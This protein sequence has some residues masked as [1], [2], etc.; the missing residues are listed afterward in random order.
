MNRCKKNVFPFQWRS[1]PQLLTVIF[2]RFT[3]ATAPVF[4]V[5]ENVR[6][7]FDLKTPGKTDWFSGIVVKVHKKNRQCEIDFEAK[8]GFDANRETIPFEEIVR[9][10]ATPKRKSSSP[11]TRPAKKRR[12]SA[13]K[14]MAIE[15]EAKQQLMLET[16]KQHQASTNTAVTVKR[17]K[18]AKAKRS[19]EHAI[20]HTLSGDGFVNLEIVN[21]IC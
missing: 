7:L 18:V 19:K 4:S 2:S 14:K 16:A 5:G 12:L 20:A 17:R 11:S 21:D 15:E 10:T 9:E 8:H 6:V 13:S 3:M 1:V